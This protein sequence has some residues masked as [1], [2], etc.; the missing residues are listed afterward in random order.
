MMS[1]IVDLHVVKRE[2]LPVLHS[3][4]LKAW[5]AST[6]SGEDDNDADDAEEAYHEAI[7]EY[8]REVSFD[9]SGYVFLYLS[10]YLND[11]GVELGK[12]TF[13]PSA[14]GT[15]RTRR[16]LRDGDLHH[17]RQQGAPFKA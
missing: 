14:V 11:H 17:A 8:G 12:L 9:W 6:G 2:H 3:A 10:T 5:E 15:R 13:L 7:E 1:S 16:A 4:Y